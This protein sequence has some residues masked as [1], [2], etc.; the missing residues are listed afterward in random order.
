MWGRPTIF[1][2][3]ISSPDHM[4]DH[5]LESPHRDDSKQ[6]SN[7]GFAEEITQAILTD[8]N[9]RH[10]IWSSVSSLPVSLPLLVDVEVGEV[11]TL[12]H[13]ELLSRRVRVFLPTLGPVEYGRH[14]QHRHDDLKHTQ[15]Y[16]VL[17]ILINTYFLF[18]ALSFT[19]RMTQSERALPM[20][21]VFITS[22]WLTRS[23]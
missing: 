14:R 21:K 7:I 11:V 15:H 23:S 18:Y 8:V 2:L 12:R 13:L 1:I 10:H 16:T 5:L 22:E 4:F 20:R 19:I 3:P 9:S 6:W 17:I